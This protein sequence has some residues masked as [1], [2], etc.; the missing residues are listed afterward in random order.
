MK[1]R[2]GKQGLTA[3]IYIFPYKR[4]IAASKNFAR[5]YAYCTTIHYI[6]NYVKLK[7]LFA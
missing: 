3:Q 6:T 2:T 7:V 4:Y 5:A 1:G